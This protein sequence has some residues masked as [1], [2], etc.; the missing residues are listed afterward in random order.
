MYRRILK[1]IKFLK[2]I[3]LL[4]ELKSLLHLYIHL[5]ALLLSSLDIGYSIRQGFSN[6]MYCFQLS[7]EKK[8]S[9]MISFFTSQGLS[10]FSSKCRLSNDSLDM[11]NDFLRAF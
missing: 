5:K 7:F 9:L 1:S 6:M 10:I 8:V 4:R 2:S 11:E 3:L